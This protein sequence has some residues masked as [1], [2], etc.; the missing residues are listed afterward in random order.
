MATQLMK[1]KKKKTA[2]IS[3]LSMIYGK[4]KFIS[5]GYGAQTG[6]LAQKV[7]RRTREYMYNVWVTT[8]CGFES[9]AGKLK[10]TTRLSDETL[11]EFPCE[12]VHPLPEGRSSLLFNTF[13]NTPF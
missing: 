4:K 1:S 3:N 10:I 7:E 9:S 11:N 6:R 8:G 5:T 2:D 13:P 12:E